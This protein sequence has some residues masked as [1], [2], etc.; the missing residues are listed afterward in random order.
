MLRNHIEEVSD[1]QFHFLL[2]TVRDKVPPELFKK[3]YANPV[4]GNPEQIR[5][6]LREAIRLLKEAGYDGTPIVLKYP[7]NP[8][9][10]AIRD[11]AAAF[12]PQPVAAGRGR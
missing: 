10:Q 1:V 7:T 6:N 3:P 4:N 11:L 9:S 5:S 12:R 2:E 8:T